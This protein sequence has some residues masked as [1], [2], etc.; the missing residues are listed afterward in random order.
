[1]NLH[2]FETFDAEHLSDT[3]DSITTHT[4]YH[5]TATTSLHLSNMFWFVLWFPPN[6]VKSFGLSRTPKFREG[7]FVRSTQRQ[8]TIHELYTVWEEG[9]AT[10]DELYAAW[11]KLFSAWEKLYAA[12][13][14]L[15]AARR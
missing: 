11:E 8:R 12:Q 9:Y 2:D 13:E 4:A 7:G 1:M 14:E 6:A 3:D 15:Y 5:F 10:W